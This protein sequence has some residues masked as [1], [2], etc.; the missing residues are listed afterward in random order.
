[1]VAVSFKRRCEIDEAAIY[2][3]A[4]YLLS[5]EMQLSSCNGLQIDGETCE[6]RVADWEEL[7]INIRTEMDALKKIISQRINVCVSPKEERTVEDAFRLHEILHRRE[8][9]VCKIYDLFMG[10]LEASDPR[11]SL[12]N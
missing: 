7:I 5:I 9:V 6:K 12:L 11:S 3:D 8:R 2:T 1:M 10:L 4:Q